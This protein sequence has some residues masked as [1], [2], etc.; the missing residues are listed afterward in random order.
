MPGARIEH[1]VQAN[2]IFV[3]LPEPVIRGLE[4]DGFEFYRWV[5][6]G[7]LL[8]LVTSFNTEPAHVEAFLASARRHAARG[9]QAAQ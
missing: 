2:E 4:Q 1:P 7:Q 5:E 9:I 6:G 3:T 8:R